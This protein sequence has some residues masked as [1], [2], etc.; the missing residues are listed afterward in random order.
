MLKIYYSIWIYGAPGIGFNHSTI[1]CT[2]SELN[3]VL[4]ILKKDRTVK[5]EKISKYEE[6]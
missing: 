6:K 3:N 1:I 5:I 2:E 4:S